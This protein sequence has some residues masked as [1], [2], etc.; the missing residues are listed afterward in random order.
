M[1]TLT[2]DCI[3]IKQC[4]E[5]DFIKNNLNYYDGA[6][7]RLAKPKCEITGREDCC[8]ETLFLKAHE[9]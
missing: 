1:E 4:L 7:F 3:N 9:R 6:I 8:Y 2:L 5:H